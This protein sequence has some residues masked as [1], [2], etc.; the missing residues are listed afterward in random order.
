MVNMILLFAF[1][2][3][4]LIVVASGYDETEEASL[5]YWGFGNCGKVCFLSVFLFFSYV[6]LTRSIEV[7]NS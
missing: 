5:C 1:V 7:A 2:W 3:V 6:L 4:S